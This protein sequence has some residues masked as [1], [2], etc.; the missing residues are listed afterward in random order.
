[1]IKGGGILTQRFQWHPLKAEDNQAKHRISFDEATTVFDDPLHEVFPDPD[2]SETEVRLIALGTSNK[3][4]LLFVSFV[5]R[6]ESIRIISA[7][8]ATRQELYDY[9]EGS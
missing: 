4:N 3:A 5:E 1:L 7:R 9:E 6:D 2:H 8:K